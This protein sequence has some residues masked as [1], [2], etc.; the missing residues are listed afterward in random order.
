M[1][2][3]MQANFFFSLNEADDLVEHAKQN[4]QRNTEMFDWKHLMPLV[5]GKEDQVLQVI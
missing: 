5:P 3:T 1:Y 4:E 2:Q